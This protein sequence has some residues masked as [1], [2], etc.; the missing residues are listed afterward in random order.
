MIF[1]KE[2][3]ASLQRNSARTAIES[4]E[5]NISYA[6]L[7]DAANKVTRY[8]LSKYPE[9][10]TVTGVQLRNRAEII[11][12]MIGI[13]NARHV[14]LPIDDK[15]P[16]KRR[17][18]MLQQA[19][20]SFIITSLD[21]LLN[22]ESAEVA[23][24]A[25]E[26]DD[27]L[28]I[29][30]TSGSTGDPKG[31]V[32]RNESLL[33]FIQ[34]ELANFG[35]VNDCRVSQFISPYFDAFL[36]DV[37]VALFSGGTVCIP[38]AS[39]ELF[40]PEKIVSWID[41]QS[42]T[43]IHCV[44]SVFRVINNGP[45]SPEKFTSLR[46]ILLS[47]EKIIPTELINW[48][49]VFGD[50][51]QLV[52]LYGPT[53]TTMIRS[54]YN[55]RPADVKL[56]RIPVGRP[57]TGTEF[58]IAGE[59]LKPCA[60]LV[61][62]DLYIITQYGT[63]GYLNAPELNAAKFIEV[64]GVKMFR[65]GDK[66]RTLIDGNIDL[67][68][69]E[70]RQV[71]LRGIRIELDEI[72]N[73]LAR[74]E[75]IEQAVVL[76]HGEETGTERLTAF[77]TRKREANG[78]DLAAVAETYLQEH[79][80]EYMI[81]AAIIEVAQFPL[82]SNGKIN[83]KELLQ[84]LAS[85]ELVQPVNKTEEKILSIWK[86]I[87]GDKPVS[88]TDSFN[89]LGGNS[90][91]IMRLIGKIYKEFN[92]RISLNDLFNNLTIQKQ[93]ALVQQAAGD[94]VL[95]IQKAAVKQG[96]HL[97]SAQERLYYNYE[98]NKSGTAFNL[99]MAWEMDD[100]IDKSRIAETLHKLI[101]RHESLR[102]EF[103][104][105]NGKLVQVVKDKVDFA[106]EEIKGNGHNVQQLIAGFVK[107]FDLSRAPLIRC[108]IIS[109]G[110]NS[111]VLILDV[112]HIVCDGMSQVILLSDFLALYRGEALKPLPVQYKDY[113]EWEYD[114]KTTNEYIS[115]RE[116]WLR[117]FEGK[118]PVLELPIT[119]QPGRVSEEGGNAFFEVPDA[120]I[121]PVLDFLKKEDITSFSGWFSIYFL[122]L[123]Q[124]TGQDDI[125]IGINTTGR[126]Q[127]ELEGVV[128]M[129]VKTLPIRYRLQ[130]EL[131]F[132]ELV[133]GMHKH[134]IQANSRQVY[135]LAD[136]LSELNSNRPDPIKSLFDAMF[137]FQNY[138]TSKL[139]T[140]NDGFFNYEFENTTSKYPLTLFASET[141]D[142]FRF[143][144]EYSL[145]YFTKTDIELLILHFRS[146]VKRIA[147]NIN[148]SSSEHIGAATATRALAEENISFNF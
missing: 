9:A 71:K 72:E 87:L 85:T 98:L 86:E 23:Y 50:R 109:T 52:N 102:T 11:I 55:I 140:R 101:E 145:A 59:D 29:Y 22:A 76:K 88:T 41:E 30:F 82:L 54:C 122:F 107:P 27:G 31:I 116:F 139:Q 69:R 18:S 24:P 144:L 44:P 32:G 77:V 14:F 37:F 73:V 120:E 28:Y 60:P 49:Q 79:L 38:P 57:I 119:V 20:P 133:R 114:F 132:K 34:W 131:S 47:G 111:K 26:G 91:S 142:A 147:A 128:G 42:I 89:S 65:T 53:E 124:L 105:V 63:K 141:R 8:L 112:H 70:D 75:Y 117:S 6:A 138:D 17:T 66:A 78:A 68:G 115:H 13:F 81:P 21:E 90:I 80:P 10:G 25:W 100:A 136:I 129:F 15:L 127:D 121:R 143:R 39:D 19:Q 12:A 103:R 92:V 118:V 126:M 106:V 113:A 36:R 64:N 33:Q 7:L 146:L 58:L 97:S 135:D 1:Q 84:K 56:A 51:I 2:L 40:T 123:S 130:P 46:F 94:D 16:E 48:Y 5:N 61:A 43:L 45:L 96:Y 110:R 137:V 83:Y 148:A 3:L 95:H 67:I 134:L 4:G 125:V 62:G 93:A 35:I 74:C 104:F 99:P 108:A